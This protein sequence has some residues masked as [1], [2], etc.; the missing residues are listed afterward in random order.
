MTRIR[1]IGLALLAMLAIGAV[2]AGAASAKSK[3][4][5]YGNG[6]LLPVGSPVLL[7]FGIE[8]GSCEAVS[9]EFDEGTLASNAATTDK[10]IEIGVRGQCADS[11]GGKKD[12][13]TGGTMT[14]KLSEPTAV[15]SMYLEVHVW[16]P[17]GDCIYEFTKAKSGFGAE[18]E[19]VVFESVV[20]GKLTDSPR[21][22]PKSETTTIGA[23]LFTIV[24]GEIVPV[25]SL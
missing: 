16:G 14:M 2:S 25:T 12:S 6:E 3:V 22:C 15:L 18:I 9:P 8:L 19:V 20:K 5:L 17:A 21:G 1:I 13:I 24:H 7:E 4:Y 23:G 10:I 11:Y